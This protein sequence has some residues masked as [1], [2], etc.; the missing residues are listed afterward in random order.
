MAAVCWISG[1]W[2][3]LLAEEET[4]SQA[5]RSSLSYSITEFDIAHDPEHPDLPPVEALLKL[6]IKLGWLKERYVAERR[7]PRRVSFRLGRVPRYRSNV[8]DATA[9]ASVCQQI[10]ARLNR[11]GLI[12]IYVFPA[13]DDIEP[14]TGRDLRAEQSGAL[15]IRINAFT[16]SQLQTSASDKS[17]SRRERI[18][19]RRHKR[20]R[21]GSPVRPEPRRKGETDLLR[22]DLIDEYVFS[23]NRHPSRRLDVT[24]RAAEGE[25]KALLDYSVT[26]LKPWF[27]YCET[28]NTGT[29]STGVWRGHLGYVHNQITGHD[30][31][32]SADF[33][34]SGRD[35][36][37][38]F[39]SYSAPTP[40]L[41]R[42][43]LKLELAASKYEA[44]EIG[45]ADENVK[46]DSASAALSFSANIFQ[47]QNL[48]LDL[49]GG[50]RVEHLATE[51]NAV[52]IEGDSE[53]F[54]A[55]AGL[56]AER[57][58]AT[59]SLNAMAKV[60][61][62]FPGVLHTK[63]DDL[64]KLGRVSPDNNWTVLLWNAS[65]SIFLEPVLFRKAWLDPSTP[66]SSTLAHE[67]ALLFR[68][69]F[70]F[71]GKRLNPQS[72][73]AVG[74][75]YSVRGYDE[76]EVAGD[77]TF[78]STAEYR[79]HFPRAIKP[80]PTPIKTRQILGKPFR[81]AAAQP[82]GRPDW[83]LIF[84][85]FCDYGLANIND[86]LA[87]ESN[88]SLT[89]AGVGVELALFNNLR[90]RLDWGYVLEGIKAG[91]DNEHQKGDSR[92]HLQFLFLW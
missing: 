54:I 23:K 67:L 42:I 13:P 39:V 20:F 35:S 21:D 61:H 28:S 18:N 1:P 11:I 64:E 65:H 36:N 27:L 17:L 88:E 90:A 58:S 60:E 81:F 40:G 37:S 44:D 77:T 70:A 71:G 69:Q 50:G 14:G 24:V 7:G 26:D 5:A 57:N 41:S 31:I 16:V 76:A 83:D 82:Y 6:R 15:R 74:G 78:V 47:H 59:M 29:D 66:R 68:G 33:F 84:R 9:V 53:L 12:G 80:L 25:G 91:T 87:F 3:S 19:L 52:E 49:L 56:R 79:F 92:F 89:S 72:Q 2:H 51:N 43:R 85:A 62:L 30:D 22:K 63:V 38:A 34:T 75:F 48:F 55:F 4:P 45:I 46:G 32:L 8:F 73:E 10:L 86:R